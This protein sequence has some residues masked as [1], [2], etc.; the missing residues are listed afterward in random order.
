[1]VIDSI[2]QIWIQYSLVF[3]G[4]QIHTAY[5]LISGRDHDAT[6]GTLALEPLT[7]RQKLSQE[8]RHEINVIL[9]DAT[10]CFLG[11]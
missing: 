8:Q 10:S 6:A 5:R 9:V 7:C 4:G 3:G 11:N 1:M 2:E